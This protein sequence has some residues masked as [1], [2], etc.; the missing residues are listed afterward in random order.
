MAVGEGVNHGVEDFRLAEVQFVEDCDCVAAQ[1]GDCLDADRRGLPCANVSVPAVC[2]TSAPNGCRPAQDCGLAN[3]GRAE[4]VRQRAADTEL[5]KQ[6]AGECRA[7]CD[8]QIRVPGRES[9]DIFLPA[10]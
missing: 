5:A 1:T 6:R 7:N 10:A 2:L 4:E 3:R 8:D 9:G